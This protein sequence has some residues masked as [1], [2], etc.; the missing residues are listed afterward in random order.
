S[1]DYH[2]MRISN[3]TLYAHNWV[4]DLLAETGLAGTLAYLA[5]LGGIAWLCWRGLR[6][7][8]EMTIRTAII[9]CVVG[10][11]GI[12]AGALLTPMT[13]WP[14]GTGSLHAMLGTTLGIAL[15]ANGS[16]IIL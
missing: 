3:L 15:F 6:H 13:R 9:G 10:L 7:T 11:I 4:L 2:L 14:V 12:L 16:N 8:S 1:P 5:F